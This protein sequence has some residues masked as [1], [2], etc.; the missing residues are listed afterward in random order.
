MNALLRD[1]NGTKMCLTMFN[2]AVD[3]CNFI[4]IDTEY[5]FSDGTIKPARVTD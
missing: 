1:K 5:L 3:R 2:T 4:E